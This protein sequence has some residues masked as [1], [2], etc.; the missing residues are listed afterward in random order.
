MMRKGR[1]FVVS[2]PSGAGKTTLCNMLLAKFDALAYSVSHTTRPPRVGEVDGQ[3]YFFVSKER[4]NELI[5]QGDFLEYATVHNNLYGTS[6]SAIE[7][8]LAEGRDLLLDIDPQ[9]AMQLKS[10]IDYGIYIFIMPP[11]LEELRARLVKRND[12]DTIELRLHNAVQELQY[13]KEYD[14]IVTNNDLDRAFYE[15]SSIYVAERCRTKVVSIKEMQG[16][17]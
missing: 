13:A 8:Q 4:F 15:L 6:K 14:Y 3:Q 16:D 1:L 17:I 9:G 7:A 11:S 12:T 2:A 5:E 10:G